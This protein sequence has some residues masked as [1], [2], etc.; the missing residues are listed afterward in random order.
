[1]SLRSTGAPVGSVKP[2]GA[3]YDALSPAK[4]RYLAVW[5][6]YPETRSG[7]RI[8]IKGGMPF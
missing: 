5:D 1:L 8:T 4:Q 3:A 6:Y 2:D 7:Y